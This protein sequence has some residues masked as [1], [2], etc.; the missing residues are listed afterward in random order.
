LSTTTGVT[1]AQ[2]HTTQIDIYLLTY[3]Q[4]SINNNPSLFITF[5]AYNVQK[6][7]MQYTATHNLC[8]I[9]KVRILQNTN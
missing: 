4:H 8:R 1:I 6:Y 7:G 9:K 2:N 3:L 5:L